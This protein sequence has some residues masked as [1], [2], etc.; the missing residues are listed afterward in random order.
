MNNVVKV[1]YSSIPN[2]K[3][4]IRVNSKQKAVSQ[5][6]WCC[7]LQLVVTSRQLL[8]LDELK[9]SDMCKTPCIYV[10]AVKFNNFLPLVHETEASNYFG[11]SFPPQRLN[12]FVTYRLKIF[13]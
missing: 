10:F 13:E 3:I 4:C 6:G 11:V 1:V 5:D 12:F 8:V 9:K 7:Q 2:I